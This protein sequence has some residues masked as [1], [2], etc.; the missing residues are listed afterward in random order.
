[1]S[2]SY[3]TY[4]SSGTKEKRQKKTRQQACWQSRSVAGGRYQHVPLI[5]AII[6]VYPLT[7]DCV[8]QIQFMYVC[9]LKRSVAWLSRTQ[10]FTICF[11]ELPNRRNHIRRHPWHLV[12]PSG[13]IRNCF[14]LP[15]ACET[16]APL[17]LRS[18]G[19]LAREH[20]VNGG[21]CEIITFSLVLI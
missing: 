15:Y 12:V 2:R 10:I 13:V 20:R 17:S 7:T 6:D 4:N 21:N 18:D 19:L 14:E 3:R 1:M 5:L 8:C 16:Q 11:Q 9:Q